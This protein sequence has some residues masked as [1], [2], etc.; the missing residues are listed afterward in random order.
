MG[1]SSLSIDKTLILGCAHYLFLTKE[2]QKVLI[3]LRNIQLNGKYLYR[4]LIAPNVYLID[5][6]VN[7]A[8]ALYEYLIQ[9]KLENNHPHTQKADFFI[10][11]PNQNNPSIITDSDKSRF[12]YD[13]KYGR[14]AGEN[15]E[16]IQ[17]VP[18]STQYVPEEIIKR[19][20]KQIPKVFN[21]IVASPLNKWIETPYLIK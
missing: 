18:F 20:Q 4:N 10:S 9:Q 3:E 6:S 13:Y 12:T 7:T 21:L 8:E 14:N 11:I 5:P 19:F 2:I 17:T 16:Y 15:Q 1:N